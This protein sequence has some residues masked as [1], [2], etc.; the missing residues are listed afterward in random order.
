MAKTTAA[1]MMMVII[2]VAPLLI[3]KL[4]DSLRT[5]DGAVAALAQRD[6]VARFQQH[7]D[8]PQ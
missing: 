2:C 5:V 4:C 7:A 3:P 8:A 6:R 1:T